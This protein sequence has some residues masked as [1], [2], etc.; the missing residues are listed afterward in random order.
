MSLLRRLALASA[1]WLLAQGACAD[2]LAT[3]DQCAARAPGDSTGGVALEAQCPG[4]G[5]ALAELGYAPALPPDWVDH[6]GIAGLR[7][8]ARLAHQ[9]REP[10][11]TTPD[12]APVAAILRQLD[13]EQQVRPK[14]SWWTVLMDKLGSWFARGQPTSVPWLDRLLERMAGA[15][16]FMQVLSYTLLAIVVAIIGYYAIRELR[17]SGVLQRRGDEQRGG[18]MPAPAGVAPTPDLE[19]A[20][21]HEQPALLLRLLV[22]RLRARGELQQDRSLTHAELIAHSAFRDADSRHRFERVTRLAERVLYGAGK[23]DPAQVVEVVGEGRKL[24]VQIEGP[25]P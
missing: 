3:L 12:T 14:R 18:A 8:L 10:R 15:V 16:D 11:A 6:L 22:A 19:T 20:A 13:Q 17:A 9:D 25:G 23:P 21:L 4:I 1:A 5:A 7:D 2:A 24:L